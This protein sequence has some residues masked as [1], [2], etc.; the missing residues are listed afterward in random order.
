MPKFAANLSMMFPELEEPQRFAAARKAGFTAVEFL[1]PYAHPVAEVRRWLDDAG[2]EMILLNTPSGDA[3]KGERGL[4]ALPGREADFRTSFE[5]ALEYA[6]GLGVGM[7]HVLAGTVPAGADA[8][9]YEAKFIENLGWA[10]GLA[11]TAG[12]RIN[13]E[14]LNTRDA[15]GY[16]HIYTADT[17][18]IIESVGADNVRL[19]YDLYHM[20]I[21]Q[22]D[23]VEGL[24]RNLDI[25][26]HVQFSSLP[27]RHEPQYGEVNLPLVFDAIDAMGYTGWLGCEYAPKAGTLEG[28]RGWGKV[29]GLGA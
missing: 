17:R 14:P 29:Y 26:G 15:P 7:I 5:K 8:A 11:K 24:R 2:L 6:T 25:V 20:Q 23:L 4:G 13:L 9:A 27:G 12:V 18:R 10:S 22:G 21:M 16:L 19:Q 3:S 28:L 1:R